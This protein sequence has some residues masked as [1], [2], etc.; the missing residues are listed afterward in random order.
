MTWLA[1]LGGVLGAMLWRL[2]AY[3]FS[4]L[5]QWAMVDERGHAREWFARVTARARR[6][7]MPEF[8]KGMTVVYSLGAHSACMPGLIV[9]SLSELT[10]A[11]Q[12]PLPDDVLCTVVC[13]HAMI[14]CDD[15]NGPRCNCQVYALKEVG[16]ART[17]PFVPERA[18]HVPRG[19]P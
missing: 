17:H 11:F 6:H 9:P 13:A 8:R 7:K 1:I 3:S 4:Q 10:S 2:F 18:I 14:G 15:P 12:M 19:A 16:T 5:G